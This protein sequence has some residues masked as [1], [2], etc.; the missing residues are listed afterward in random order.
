VSEE[1]IAFTTHKN[2][3]FDFLLMV[4]IQVKPQ[5]VGD[6]LRDVKLKISPGLD[7]SNGNLWVDT[8]FLEVGDAALRFFQ[9]LYHRVDRPK[10]FIHFAPL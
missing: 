1:Q 2:K 4:W 7:S 6:K 8:D 5:I 9:K 3:I 10:V